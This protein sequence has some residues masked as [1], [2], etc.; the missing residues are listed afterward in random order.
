V[1]ALIA[2]ADE[3]ASRRFLEFF[4]ANIRNTHTRR[5]YGRARRGGVSD[6]VRKSARA[7]RRGHV[8]ASRRRVDRGND[9]LRA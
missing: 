6:L 3:R 7:I 8:A 1:P 2:A 4:A 9:C 5:G